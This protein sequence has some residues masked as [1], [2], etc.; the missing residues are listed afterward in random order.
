MARANFGW[1]WVEL[2]GWLCKE[3]Q[4]CNYWLFMRGA[5]HAG[6]RRRG[7]K[8]CAEAAKNTKKGFDLV[9]FDLVSTLH[10]PNQSFPR[11]TC[12]HCVIP[13][14]AGIHSGK[15]T[16]QNHRQP[17]FMRPTARKRLAA[18]MVAGCRHFGFFG[19]RLS[20]GLTCASTLHSPQPVIPAQAGI[21]GG[22]QTKQN[23]RNQHNQ[24]S[25]ALRGINALQGA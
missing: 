4:S 18:R 21:H 7:S 16:K 20:F 17:A 2:G 8:G 1:D 9:W 11:S 22:N 5:L 19:L 3:W 24:H 23:H 6:A 10:S 14:Q 25:C 15:Q 13:A 12:P